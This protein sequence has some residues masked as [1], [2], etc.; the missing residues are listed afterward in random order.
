VHYYERGG[1]PD[2]I[3]KDS[4]RKSE[5]QQEESQKALGIGGFREFL[6]FVARWYTN[7]EDA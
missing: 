7:S 2:K 4:A 6:V 1:E 3:L 5:E